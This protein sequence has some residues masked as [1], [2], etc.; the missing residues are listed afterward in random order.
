MLGASAMAFDE[1]VYVLNLDARKALLKA[2]VAPLSSL[3]LIAP[4]AT[5][6]HAIPLSGSI[7]AQ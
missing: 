1:V 2:V 3:R 4:L 5:A 6:N 7:I